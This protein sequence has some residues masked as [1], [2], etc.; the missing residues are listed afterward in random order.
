MESSFD[1]EN[2]K[3]DNQSKLE[4]PSATSTSEFVPTYSIQLFEYGIGDEII[5]RPAL[6]LQE[7]IRTVD[8]SLQQL[9]VSLNL[10][11]Q[12]LDCDQDWLQHHGTICGG[13][14]EPT[15]LSIEEAT[16]CVVNTSVW[17]RAALK[18][19]INHQR[20]EELDYE[21]TLEKLLFRLYRATH[22]CQQHLHDVGLFQ[23]IELYVEPRSWGETG[24][25]IVRDHMP[26]WVSDHL[27]PH[28]IQHHRLNGLSAYINTVCGVIGY[29]KRSGLVLCVYD[30]K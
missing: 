21:W 13:L 11:E 3:P 24:T 6:F 10:G 8:L 25:D 26:D 14:P 5:E 18:L 2:K 9:L 22:T 15:W 27:S 19:E 29:Q 1:I 23:G 7:P 28:P 17:P 16:P 4:F 20:A 12:G 30:T